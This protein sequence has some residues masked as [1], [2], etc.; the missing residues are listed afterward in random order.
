MFCTEERP[1]GLSLAKMKELEVKPVPI[2]NV[3]CF[4]DDVWEAKRSEITVEAVLKSCV[5]FIIALATVI[6]NLLFLLILRSSKYHRHI[7]V[8]VENEL[9]FFPPQQSYKLYSFPFS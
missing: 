7:H 1:Q 9:F 2:A 5:L 6:A 8:Q 4:N 3:S